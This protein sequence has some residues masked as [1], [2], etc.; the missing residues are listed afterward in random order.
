MLF[1]LSSQRQFPVKDEGKA[2]YCSSDWG[3]IFGNDELVAFEPFN[4][5]NNCESY[6]DKS[7]YDIPEKD[8]KNMLTNKMSNRFTITELEVWEVKF[9]VIYNIILINIGL[10]EREKERK[11]ETTHRQQT[12][13]VIT[14]I[15]ILKLHFIS[16]Q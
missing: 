3:P 16:L 4:G 1:N 11:R 2:I 5:V 7:V 13:H 6:A 8:G 9:I 10:R 14:V 12:V 15:I